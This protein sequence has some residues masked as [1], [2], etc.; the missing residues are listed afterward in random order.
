MKRDGT[1]IDVRLG[2]TG[3]KYRKSILLSGLRRNSSWNNS[4]ANDL[5]SYKD[6]IRMLL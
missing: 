4:R 3:E 6:L 1:L 2:C 5:D